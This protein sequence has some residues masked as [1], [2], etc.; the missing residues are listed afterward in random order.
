MGKMLPKWS[1][2][3]K[4]LPSGRLLCHRI[5]IE[6]YPWA[7][8][9]PT[10]IVAMLLMYGSRF[11]KTI[12]SRKKKGLLYHTTMIA[13]C[14][15]QLLSIINICSFCCRHIHVCGVSS[16]PTIQCGLQL[17]SLML[18]QHNQTSSTL[19]GKTMLYQWLILCWASSYIYP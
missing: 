18:G 19:K 13:L 16:M 5:C 9:V 1:V 14:T 6:L 12:V 2:M 3:G 10:V 15:H 11:N 17:V 7:K 4:M 8:C